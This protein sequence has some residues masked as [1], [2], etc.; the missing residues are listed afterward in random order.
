M[1]CGGVMGGPASFAKFVN[2]ILKF[3]SL[4]CPTLS[5]GHCYVSGNPVQGGVCEPMPDLCGSTA[6][7][8]FV[9]HSVMD[10]LTKEV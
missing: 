6:A 7:L 9:C 3:R 2:I 5:R 10:I 4:F 8:R 1:R